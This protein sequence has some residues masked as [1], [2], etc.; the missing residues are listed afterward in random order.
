MQGKKSGLVIAAVLFGL[1]WHTN[2]ALILLIPVFAWGF[3]VNRKIFAAKDLLIP[4]AVF[5][6]LSSPLV[7]FEARHGF[8]QTRALFSQ[9]SDPGAVGGFWG[10]LGHVIAYASRNASRL[11]SLSASGLAFKLVPL[12]LICSLAWLL[13]TRRL[14]RFFG[15][16]FLWWLIPYLLFFTRSPLNLSE[17]YLNGLNIWW[18][19]IA[20]LA[21]SH[22]RPRVLSLLILAFFLSHNLGSFM[23]SPVNAS[24]YLAKKSL[25]RFISAD[26]AAH[27]YPCVSI[28]YIT[29][30]GY[31]LGYR[32]FFWLNNLHANQPQSGSPVYTIV[33]PHSLVDRLDMTF[34]AL[35]LILP[36][37]ERYSPLAVKLSCQGENANLTDPMFGFT[38]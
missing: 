31:D 11:F 17:Y 16:I 23:A 22:L 32:Y 28:S 14:P 21:L 18:I 26:A 38:K 13:V 1:A 6:L 33:F 2:L 24:G 4:L 12:L 30:P 27:G 36:D 15:S 7:I 19:V 29:D 9:V 20:A 8:I 37:Y 3:W 34:G 5:V 10:Q 25:V 35:G